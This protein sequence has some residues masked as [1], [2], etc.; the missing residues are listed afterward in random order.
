MHELTV[1]FKKV[2]F[3]APRIPKITLMNDDAVVC[4]VLFCSL[5]AH[6]DF[7]SDTMSGAPIGTGGHDLHF[8][9]QRGQGDI[10]WELFISQAFI[11]YC[12]L[13]VV[14]ILV[15]GPWL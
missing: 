7:F 13:S 6:H 12:Q 15:C 1:I 14:F 10:I 5:V 11:L 8:Q 4:S 3:W 2:G 9:R